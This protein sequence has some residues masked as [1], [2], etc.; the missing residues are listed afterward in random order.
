MM[1]FIQPTPTARTIFFVLSDIILSLF[2]LLLAYKLRFNFRVEDAYMDKFWIMYA[3]LVA[4][5]IGVMWTVRIYQIPWRFFSLADVKRIVV[6]QLVSYGIFLSV[7]YMFSEEFLPFPRS[8]LIIDFLLSILFIGGFRMSKRLLKEGRSVHEGPK[9]ILIGLSPISQAMFKESYDFRIVAIVDDSPMV[10]NTYVMNRKVH[11]LEAIETLSQNR[12]ATT[13]IIGKQIDPIEQQKIYKRLNEIGI[14]DIYILGIENQADQLR[15]VT[16]EELL[17]RNPHD[18]DKK[19]IK[20]FVA[21]KNILITGAGGS[22]G[23]EIANQCHNLGASSLTLV[24]NSEYNLYQIGEQ[25]PDASLKLV[26]IS[27]K[28]QIVKVMME[29]KPDIVIHAAAYKHVPICEDNQEMAIKNNII[30][31]MNVID[32]AIV[33]SAQKVVIISTDKAVRPTNIM[34][35]TKRVVELYAQNVDSKNT[36]VVAVRFGN[37]LGSSGSVIPKFREQ[38]EQGGPITVTHPDI[39]RYFM[40]IPEACELV[41]QAASVAKGGEL[42]ILDMGEPIKIAD[43]ARQMI[44]LSGKDGQVDIKFTGLRPGEKL[45]EELLLDDSERKTKYSSIFI[46]HPTK[47]DISQLVNDISLLLEC[48]DKVA[49]LQAIVPEF[50][51][52]N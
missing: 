40:L 22:I 38:I 37:V 47:Y 36:E 49:G 35:A 16:L 28:E 45:Y 44:K 6:S 21:N 3:I 43:L 48:E 42:F 32:A 11:P 27:N 39:T 14:H 17:A 9:T 8:I 15:K 13:A 46:A 12:E 25:I 29:S 30:G 52:K 18:L 7:L 10:K 50:T 51:R 20:S 41:L 23:S 31:S 5:K 19:L 1:P 33:N 2:T 4:I 34:G 24:D 26:D